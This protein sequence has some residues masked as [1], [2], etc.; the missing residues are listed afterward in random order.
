[1]RPAFRFRCRH[2][3][4]CARR[5]RTFG[6]ASHQDARRAKSVDPHMLAEIR[7][8]AALDRC[9]TS[10]GLLCR[11]L[12][13]VPATAHWA[14]SKS[15]ETLGIEPELS[16]AEARPH[17]VKPLIGA[18]RALDQLNAIRTHL[19]LTVGADAG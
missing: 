2:P 7:A 19:L 9:R 17:G 15:L 18:I 10:C 14:Q 16:T 12:G 13:C 3:A 4:L 6:Q 1:M 11:R 8:A 5:A